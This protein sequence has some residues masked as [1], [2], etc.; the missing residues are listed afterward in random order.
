MQARHAK[1]LEELRRV[2]GLYRMRAATHAELEYAGSQARM[3]ESYLIAA[4]RDMELSRQKLNKAKDDKQQLETAIADL[5]KRRSQTEIVSDHTGKVSIISVGP[6][7]QI[8]K[9]Q[10]L[11]MIA[12]PA[13]PELHVSVQEAHV[14]QLQIGQGLSVYI[15]ELGRDISGTVREATPLADSDAGSALVKINLPSDPMLTSGLSGKISVRDGEYKSLLVPFNAVQDM[16]NDKAV[17]VV[18]GDGAVQQRSVVLGRRYGDRVE[19]V[20]EIEESEKVVLP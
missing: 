4:Q 16:G 15:P 8:S 13:Q 20:S 6:G 14:P 12:V 17:N 7:D 18:G 11:L 3:I 19:I 10:T 1:A 2:D 9:G 5:R